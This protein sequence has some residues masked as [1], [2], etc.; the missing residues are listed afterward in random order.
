MPLILL[1]LLVVV[2]VV[3]AQRGQIDTRLLVTLLFVAVVVWLVFAASGRPILV[4]T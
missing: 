2:L 1:I 3:L 4:E